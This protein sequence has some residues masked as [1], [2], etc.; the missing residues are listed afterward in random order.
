MGA[1]AVDRASGAS[2]RP[3]AVP[4]YLLAGCGLVALY[5]L[6]EFPFANPAVME[7]FWLCF[8]TAVRYHKLT[9]GDA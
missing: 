1:G 7:A 4:G 6:V 5:A 3:G 8:F 2:D 9:V